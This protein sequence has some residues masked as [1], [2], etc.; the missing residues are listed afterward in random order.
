MSEGSPKKLN[1][2]ELVYELFDSVTS[3]V[4][5]LGGTDGVLI[6]DISKKYRGKPDNAAEVIYNML[7]PFKAAKKLINDMNKIISLLKD[8]IRVKDMSIRSQVM[9]KDLEEKIDHIDAVATELNAH[10]TELKT[11]ADAIKDSCKTI[12]VLDAD[13]SKDVEKIVGKSFKKHEEIITRRHNVIITGIEDKDE[14]TENLIIESQR[15]IAA[16]MLT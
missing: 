16:V 10:A 9:R 4:Y 7:S 1:E 2:V 14:D 8:E 13:F 6:Q 11:Y 12:P 15:V 5:K 3:P